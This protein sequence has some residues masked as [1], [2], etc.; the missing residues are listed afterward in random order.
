VAYFSR[1]LIISSPSAISSSKSLLFA[2]LPV[3][4]RG[5][6]VGHVRRVAFLRTIGLSEPA[7]TDTNWVAIFLCDSPVSLSECWS[8]VA[9]CGLSDNKKVEECATEDEGYLWFYSLALIR[10][11]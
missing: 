4:F 10:L 6:S 11:I 7:L 5:N 1:V 3:F 8:T 9:N 2:I